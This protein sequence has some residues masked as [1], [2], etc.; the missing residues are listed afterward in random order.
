[1]EGSGELLSST[2]HL[3]QEIQSQNLLK[4]WLISFCL[5]YYHAATLVFWET[6]LIVETLISKPSWMLFGYII[7]EDLKRKNSS[8]IFIPD[9]WSQKAKPVVHES[10]STSCGNA[11]QPQHFCVSNVWSFLQHGSCGLPLRISNP[12]LSFA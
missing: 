8:P 4:R 1:M 10:C 12:Q 6:A 9:Y 7:L 5:N 11:L 2:L 3:M